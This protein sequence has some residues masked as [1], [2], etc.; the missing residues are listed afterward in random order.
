MSQGNCLWENYV[1][2]RATSH[3]KNGTEFF[4]SLSIRRK[5]KAGEQYARLLKM[6][7]EKVPA[8]PSSKRT[9]FC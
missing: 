7:I 8:L 4:D 5:A 9:G 1:A 6:S 2:M 3:V